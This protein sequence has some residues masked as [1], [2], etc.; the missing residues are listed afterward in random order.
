MTLKE[1]VV[2]LASETKG[3]VAEAWVYVLDTYQKYE[4][5]A[6]D[7]AG[8]AADDH[9]MH[10]VIARIGESGAGRRSNLWCDLLALVN[11]FL[12]K[13]GIGRQ[14]NKNELVDLV[15]GSLDRTMGHKGRR[16][17][18]RAGERMDARRK[19]VHGTADKWIDNPSR[20]T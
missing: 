17:A 4:E 9:F 16:K 12:L 6:Q 7:P 11:R 1:R 13:A 3:D 19:V 15:A 8:A 14:I 18:G 5:Y 10:E 2:E 20:P